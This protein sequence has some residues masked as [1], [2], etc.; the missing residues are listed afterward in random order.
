MLVESLEVSSLVIEVLLVLVLPN[1][2]LGSDLYLAE[3]SLLL[4][5]LHF[6]YF[7]LDY[8]LKFLFFCVEAEWGRST[9]SSE[10]PL[11][12]GVF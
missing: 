9:I 12:G 11:L 10:T 4:I 5:S 1:Y 2:R 3:S 6:L 7:L 8:C